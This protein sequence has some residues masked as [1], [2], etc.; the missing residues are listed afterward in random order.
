MEAG[1]GIFKFPCRPARRLKGKPLPY[2]NKAI[3]A[4]AVASYFCGPT[5]LGDGAWNHLPHRWQRNF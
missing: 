4:V 1:N 3:I 2:F 5:S